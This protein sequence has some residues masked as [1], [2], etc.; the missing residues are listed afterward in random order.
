[1][2]GKSYKLGDE[3]H[4]QIFG[5]LDISRSISDIVSLEHVKL[6]IENLE[7]QDGNPTRIL[8]RPSRT[9]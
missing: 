1:M 3:L 8:V 5:Y 2:S 4:R 7:R 9:S 6:G